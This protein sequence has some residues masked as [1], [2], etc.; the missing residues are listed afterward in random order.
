MSAGPPTISIDPDWDFAGI[1][2]L[3]TAVWPKSERRQSEATAAWAAE[4]LAFQETWPSIICDGGIELAVRLVAETRGLSPAEVLV[5]PGMRDLPALLSPAANMLS[6]GIAQR[7]EAELLEPA[8]GLLTAARGPGTD[9][10]AADFKDAVEGGALTAGSLLAAVAALHLR[11]PSLTASLNRAAG[12]LEVLR[13]R[14]ASR[15]NINEESGMKRAWAEYRGVAPLWAALLLDASD[16]SLAVLPE[17]QRMAGFFA[18][19]ERRKRVLAWA[20]WFRHFGTQH[21]AGNAKGMLL[22]EHEA[23]RFVA[24]VPLAEPPL[25]HIPD[26]VLEQARAAKGWK[27]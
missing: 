4:M 13:K 2:I 9:A 15:A 16:G 20:M 27:R 8:G 7:I 10:L 17:A 6:D 14:P 11:H 5:M 23:V 24:P 22:P 3:R 18:Q 25:G 1:A 12:I 26:E 19:P 21:K